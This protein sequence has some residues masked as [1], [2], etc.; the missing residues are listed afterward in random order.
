LSVVLLCRGFA[1]ASQ[2][3]FCHGA[4]QMKITPGQTV[5]ITGAPG[6]LGSYITEAFADKGV[7]LALVAY[8][9]ADLETLRRKMEQRGVKTI[10]LSL[11]LRER[12]QRRDLIERVRSELGE[13]DI[14]VNNAGVEFTSYYHELSEEQIEEVLSVN[15]EAAMILTRLVLP[16]MLQ[17]KAGH[18]VNISSLAGRAAPAF[19][20]AYS[21]TKAGL[22]AFTGS[23]RATYRGSGVSA[24][25]NT[26]GFV[27]AGI[28]SKLKA[29]SG[30]KAPF[31][32]GVSSPEK[33]A[34]AVIRAVENNIPELI[35]N[36]MPIRPM[37]TLSLFQPA[38]AEW[39]IEK[40]GATRFFARAAE[41]QKKADQTLKK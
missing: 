41:A 31:S 32:F 39:M 34:R 24:S 22:I 4:K 26:P 3:R 6:G 18:I 8:P 10:A 11:D 19:Q 12:S 28:Y 16:S 37:L 40:L 1:V 36:P 29:T 17:R 5:L 27:E 7:K 33:V 35:I 30:Q 15:L 2:A 13:I 20:E 9:G 21:A 14:L 23:F 25:A 38:M